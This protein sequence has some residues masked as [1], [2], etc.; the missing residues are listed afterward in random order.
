MH[1]GKAIYEEMKKRGVKPKQLASQMGIS[2]AYVYSLPSRKN[3]HFESFLGFAKSL[4]AD[5]LELFKRA[6]SLN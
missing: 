6:R 5:D 3:M 4:G 1:F 2:E